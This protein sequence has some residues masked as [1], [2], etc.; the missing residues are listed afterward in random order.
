MQFQTRLKR[1]TLASKRELE[2][3][4]DLSVW[5]SLI[6][7]SRL[8]EFS[9]PFAEALRAMA[10]ALLVEPGLS[11]ANLTPIVHVIADGEGY[12]IH[13]EKTSASGT[14]K[15]AFINFPRPLKHHV[16]LHCLFGHELGHTALHTA[17]V[18]SSGNIL[19][20]YVMV[21]LQSAGPLRSVS[22]L[23]S[24]LHAAAA[25]TQVKNWLRQYQ[26][27]YAAQFELLDYHYLKWLDEIICDLFGLL[28]FGPGFVAAHRIYLRPMHANPYELAFT[29]PPYAV[30]HKMLVRAMK[31]MGWQQPI[32][33]TP[34]H[35]LAEQD[36]LNYVLD[37]PYDA[38]AL[39]ISDQQLTQAIEGVNRVFSSHGPLGYVAPDGETL[40]NLVDRLVMRLPPVI[41]GLSEKGKP[42]L[43]TVD[44]AH[45]LYAGW[46]YSIGT[47]RLTQKPLTFLVTNMLCD[48][49][50]LQQRA[51]D[52]AVTKR[53]K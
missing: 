18:G 26:S 4:T 29:H 52:I 15:F 35:S 49:A 43:R 32:I 6:E 45:T 13:Y 47:S 48:H 23:N 31:L 36:L 3:L 44:I 20:N 1:I 50:L 12:F 7:R 2:E 11:G 41:A 24:W 42:Q 40:A 53:M 34:P 37:D 21:A 17:G 51:I 14:H 10:E 39:F 27:I 25:P 5:I 19:Q 22:T 46:V 16:L 33:P 38:W 30:R 28:L 8:G 9:W